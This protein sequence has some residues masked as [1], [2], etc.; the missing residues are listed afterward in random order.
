MKPKSIITIVL[1]LFVGASL[2]YLLLSESRE[3]GTKQ[4]T[5]DQP[6]GVGAGSETAGKQEGAEPQQTSHTIIAYYFHGAV[7]CNT[8]RAIEA[9]TTE[10]L[11]KGFSEELGKGE[12]EYR[13]IN[14]DEQENEHFVKDYELTT[15]SV[16]LVDVKSGTEKRWK[17]LPRIWELVQDKEAFLE[18]IRQETSAYLSERDV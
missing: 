18:Y 15:R 6:S 9:F 2:V 17:N 1:L 12:L 4:E 10:A 13:V 3:T 11:K 7:R 14:V 8:C 16:V 5:L